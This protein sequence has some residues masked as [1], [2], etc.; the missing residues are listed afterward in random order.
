MEELVRD[1]LG[2]VV[3]NV[4][5]FHIEHSHLERK[6]YAILGQKES[7]RPL[8]GLA[9][10]LFTGNEPDYKQFMIKQYKLFGIK[11]DDESSN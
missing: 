2:Y 9:M 11:D 10:Q 5:S 4:E 6:D 8:F 1:K 3:N 7:E